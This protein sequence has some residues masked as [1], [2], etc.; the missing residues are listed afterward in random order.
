MARKGLPAKYAKM[1]F[2]KGWKA[3]KASKSGRKSTKKKSPK[4]K[5]TI[6]RRTYMARKK[7]NGKRKQGIV[8]LAVNAATLGIALA[9]MA[10]RV[11]DHLIGGDWQGFADGMMK[12]YT[13]ISMSPEAGGINF[14]PMEAKGLFAVGGAIL[15]KKGMGVVQKH[16][17]IKL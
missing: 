5:H 3:Y 11:K 4:G 14:N 12:D 16:V 9:P 6:K 7:R 10:I 17:R 15:F 1:G 2:K 8:S 13:G